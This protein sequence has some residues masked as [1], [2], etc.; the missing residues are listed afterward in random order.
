MLIGIEHG[1]ANDPT[2][3]SGP[4]APQPAEFGQAPEQQSAGKLHLP[5]RWPGPPVEEDAGVLAAM[6]GT[7]ETAAPIRSALSVCPARV[8]RKHDAA[9]LGHIRDHGYRASSIGSMCVRK[10]RDPRSTRA[11]HA[12]KLGWVKLLNRLQRCRGAQSRR[13]RRPEWCSGDAL[14]LQ[15]YPLTLGFLVINRL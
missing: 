14:F 7:C 13:V 10:G 15:I 3:R 4:R 2:A 1:R 12:Q 8:P 9:P 5:R 6:T 11:A